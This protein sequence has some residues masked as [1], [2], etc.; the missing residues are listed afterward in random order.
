MEMRGRKK[1]AEEIVEGVVEDIF[2]KYDTNNNDF[3]DYPEF[4]QMIADLNLSVRISSKEINHIFEVLDTDHD[5]KVSRDELAEAFLAI[6]SS[7]L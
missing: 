4:C 6:R 1:S 7:I 2:K 3:I 5:G